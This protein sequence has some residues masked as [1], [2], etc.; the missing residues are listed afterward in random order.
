[1]ESHVTSGSKR[2]AVPFPIPDVLRACVRYLTRDGTVWMRQGTLRA[3]WGQCS[4]S[5]QPSWM[6]QN[7]AV[8]SGCIVSD[9]VSG[10]I[11]EVLRTQCQS[12]SSMSHLSY[13]ESTSLPQS[14]SHFV[15]QPNPAPAYMLW[16]RG[17]CVSLELYTLIWPPKWHGDS[18][19]PE[20][21]A[22]WVLT[23]NLA[24]LQ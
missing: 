15:S 20:K 17:G 24:R 12:T 6:T 8:C 14:A 9:Q 11:F 3:L 2:R 16:Q 13:T 23:T 5:F 10:P 21:P 19:T 1:M 22:R 18:P 4:A 7:L